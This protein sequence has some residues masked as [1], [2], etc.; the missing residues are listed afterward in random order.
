MRIIGGTLKG[1]EINFLRNS[2]TRPL[3]DNVKESIFNILKHSNLIETKIENSNILDLYSGIGSF[4]IECLSRGSK[5]VTFIDQNDK[6]VSILKNN[7]IK[8]LITNKTE[9]WNE[10]IENFLLKK[11]K[12]K[13]DIFFIDPPFKDFSFYHNLKSIKRKKIFQ[14]KH[15]VIIHREKKT[16]DKFEDFINIILTK[17][18]GRSKI[19]FGLF[20]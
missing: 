4:G 8:L 19:I 3:K 10:N 20:S 6:A 17:T 9:V 13:F 5:K 18:Y 11:I 16:T 15:I 1:R 7:L 2:N 14:R 12:K